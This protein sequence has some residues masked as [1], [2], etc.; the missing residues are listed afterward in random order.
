LLGLTLHEGGA[1]SKRLIVREASC[2]SRSLQALTLTMCSVSLSAHI[3]Q[4][5]ITDA[6]TYMHAMHR[7]SEYV[8]ETKW[9]GPSSHIAVLRLTALQQQT[10]S[11]VFH[12]TLKTRSE[13][14]EVRCLD[15]DGDG[16]REGAAVGRPHV[17]PAT[18]QGVEVA[19]RELQLHTLDRY[20]EKAE[21]S[22]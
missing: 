16:E 9:P 15:L 14:R 17:V 20:P 4:C 12:N 8:Q 10:V 19:V 18:A 7:D 13:A 5:T 6:D 21:H 2:A 3:S 1:C 11:Q 22:S